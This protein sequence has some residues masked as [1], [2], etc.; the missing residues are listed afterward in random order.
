VRADVA[1][2]LGGIKE[3]VQLLRGMVG[4]LQSELET[5]REILSSEVFVGGDGE[6]NDGDCGGS[7]EGVGSS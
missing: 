2:S 1:E 7:G 4:Y 3:T 5:M 6:S